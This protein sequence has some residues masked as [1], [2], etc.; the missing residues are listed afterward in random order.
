M[1]PHRLDE[2]KRPHEFRMLMQHAIGMD[3][4]WNFILTKEQKLSKNEY[5]D[6]LSE[7]LISV[8]T[9]VLEMFGIAMV[10]SVLLGC[11][12]LVPNRLA[13]RE[14]YPAKFRYR[15]EQDMR[16]MLT[17]MMHRPEEYQ[18]HLGYLRADFEN[19]SRGFFP[20]LIDV[21]RQV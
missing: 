8:S 5:L 19:K 16:L 9:A 12:P 18:S 11:I 4:N 2:E 3:S 17:E 7:S 14:M 15:D 1:F 6:T 21:M 13:Y 20:R 10:E